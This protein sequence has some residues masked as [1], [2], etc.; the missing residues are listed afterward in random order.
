MTLSTADANNKN[1]DKLPL[2]PDS[3]NCV[4]SQAQDSSHAVKP[5][6]LIVPPEQAW[7]ALQ[8]A[9]TAMPRTEIIKVSDQSLH[10]ESRSLVFRFVD[11]VNA[12]L[13]PE[14]NRID[15]RS[16]S[17]TGYSDF[18]VNKK[19]IEQLRQTLKNEKVIE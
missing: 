19:R 14:Q 2:C 3:P 18:G 15:I 11:D 1:P 7:L 6:I 9:L 8:K 10:A 4:S 16:A 12:I 13:N 5:F 17:R